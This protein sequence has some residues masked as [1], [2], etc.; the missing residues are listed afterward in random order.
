M[1][2]TDGA[3]RR[4]AHG[5]EGF[6][7][8]L[9]KNLRLFFAQLPCRALRHWLL[10]SSR[11]SGSAL[12]LLAA[13]FF[14]LLFQARGGFGKPFFELVGLGLELGVAQALIVRLEIIDFARRKDESA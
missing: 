5:G 3:P 10:I 14:Q 2:Q 12:A 13:R 6:R 1:A 9:L 7:Q 8:E 11:R 4:L